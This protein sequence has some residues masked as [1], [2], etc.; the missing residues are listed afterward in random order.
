MRLSDQLSWKWWTS[1]LLVKR[2]QRDAAGKISTST[3]TVSSHRLVIRRINLQSTTTMWRNVPQVS[4]TIN[5]GSV[6]WLPME[7]STFIDGPTTLGKV[8]NIPYRCVYIDEQE[9]SLI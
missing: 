3:A 9:K 2:D 8:V 4:F 1:W 5:L 6:S 7:A